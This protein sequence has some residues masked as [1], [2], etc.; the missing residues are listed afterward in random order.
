MYSGHDS[1]QHVQLKNDFEKRIGDYFHNLRWSDM[2]D[3]ASKIK[4]GKAT[5]GIIK[6][7]HLQHFQNLYN[8]IIQHGFV[9]RLNF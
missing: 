3:I 5:A 7:E 2:C 6:P 4:V 1:P 9:Y 8:G